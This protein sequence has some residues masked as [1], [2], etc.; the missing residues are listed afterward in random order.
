MSF[1]VLKNCSSDG[2]HL[3]HVEIRRN[4]LFYEVVGLYR[5]PSFDFNQFHDELENIMS[6]QSTHSRFFVGDMNIP[7]NLSNNNVVVRYKNLLESYNYVCSNTFATRPI[8]KNI[9][10]H[11]VCR[12]DDLGSIRN[13][14][15]YTDVSDHLLVVSSLKTNGPKES[16]VLTRKIVDKMKLNYLFTNFLNNF[17]CSDDVNNSITTIT[18]TYN[19][20]LAQCTKTKSVQVN[21]KSK[22]CPW[23]NYYVWQWIKLKHK[24]LKKVKNDPYNNNLKILLK[25]VSKRTDD[26]KKKMQNRLL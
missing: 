1:K 20:L 18:N 13:D 14:T 6:D 8:S 17:D 10:D 19:S 3:I 16:T 24:Y 4:G 15:I 9:L 11:F 26:A 22:H 12:H 7:I 23:L 25:H 2:F 21:I 5:P